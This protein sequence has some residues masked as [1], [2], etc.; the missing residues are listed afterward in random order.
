MRKVKETR[1]KFG[2]CPDAWHLGTLLQLATWSPVAH[3]RDE[4]S[5]LRTRIP[6]RQAQT[7][8]PTLVQLNC[9]CALVALS[10]LSGS[11]A[12][13]V[14]SCS[15]CRSLPIDSLTSEPLDEESASG[16]IPSVIGDMT[17]CGLVPHPDTSHHNNFPSHRCSSTSNWFAE[18]YRHM[19][20]GPAASG[21]LRVL[22]SIFRPGNGVP[23]NLQSTN[24]SAN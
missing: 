23:I 24:D 18:Q 5:A 4:P 7:E 10:S 22:A 1:C 16:V 19:L 14:C 15:T 9:P 21:E 20:L 12:T 2:A 17:F 3:A 13:Q 6:R 8:F 11:S